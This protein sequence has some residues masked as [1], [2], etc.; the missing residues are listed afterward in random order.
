VFLALVLVLV[1]AASAGGGW[2]WLYQGRDARTTDTPHPAP[3]LQR[4]LLVVLDDG[5]SE[6]TSAALMAADDAGV[7][8]VLVPGGLL[9]DIPG[10]GRRPLSSALTSSPETPAK[11]ISDALQVRIDGTWRMTLDGLR[12]LT[13]AAGGIVVDLEEE[14]TDG[15]TTLAA[16]DAQQ[17]TG[18]QATMVASALAEGET[19]EHRLAR[20]QTVLSAVLAT[21]PDQPE[22]ISDRLRALGEESQILPGTYDAAPLLR[23][24]R[25]RARDGGIAGTV[26]P[27]RTLT[28]G[29]TSVYGLDQDRAGEMVRTQLAGARF[30]EP[31]GGAVRV[32]VQNGVGVPGLG[33][34]ARDRLVGAGLRYVA[35]GNA[36][37]FGRQRTAVLVASTSGQDR[38]EGVRVA[39]ALG[40]TAENVAVDVLGTSL[41]DVVVVLGEDFADDVTDKGVGADPSLP[42]AVLTPLP[43]TELTADPTPVP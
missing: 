23:D 41:A 14:V 29:E 39:V 13:D 11:A 16:G 35:G 34:A 3:P 27:V 37:T 31:A 42:A 43:S 28:A 20:F 8:S 2:F 4:T 5:S 40:L 36:A 24:L 32:L 38:A 18:E 33:E 7:V 25:L 1:L 26:V 19:E 15:E 22:L 12:R 30:P 17:L 9:V 21:L 6:L 10:T